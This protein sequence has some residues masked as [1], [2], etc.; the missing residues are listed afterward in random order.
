M[1][2]NV[3]PAA[4]GMY[5]HK[6]R[7]FTGASIDFGELLPIRVIECFD[8]DNWTKIAAKGRLRLAPQVFPAYGDCDLR[9]A[10]FFVPEYQLIQQSSAFHSNMNS[11]KGKSVLMPWIYKYEINNMFS[12][13]T[14][15][16]TAVTGS[17]ILD[18]NKYDFQFVESVG[19]LASLAYR[20]LTK[21]GQTYFK[22]LKSLGYEFLSMPTPDS[23]T[24]ESLTDYMARISTSKDKRN[25]LPLLAYAKI[26]CDMFMN[27]HMY[28][29]SA[30]VAMLHHIHD[31]EG[32]SY[33]GY[34]MYNSSTGNFSQD[35]ILM[36]LDAVCVPHERNMY[37]DAWDTPNS[38]TGVA[39]ASEMISMNPRKDNNVSKLRTLV[40]KLQIKSTDT[41]TSIRS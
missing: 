20:R 10:A 37:L 18:E 9:T 38:P 14:T 16:S 27:S 41:I 1:N 33:G 34:T 28:N 32:Y 23:A 22:L 6:Y 13:D 31:C 17:D 36:V 24:S 4:S 26:F 19:G 29:Y 21:K 35:A 2:V 3:K 5:S 15:L 25:V 40:I 39:P 7:P 11:Y 8:S 12:R 30:L